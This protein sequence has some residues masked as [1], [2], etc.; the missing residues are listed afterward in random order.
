MDPFIYCQI[1][2]L[3]LWPK[4]HSSIS[5]ILPHNTEDKE[6]IKKGKMKQEILL[7]NNNIIIHPLITFINVSNQN[8]KMTTTPPPFF[9]W[10][11]CERQTWLGSWEAI[12]VFKYVVKKIFPSHLFTDCNSS[13]REAATF[14]SHSQAPELTC[15]YSHEQYT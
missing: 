4:D 7:H 9:F 14:F 6:K 3:K 15:I 10:S 1:G 2:Y 11:G 13:T 12:A 8:E 5:F